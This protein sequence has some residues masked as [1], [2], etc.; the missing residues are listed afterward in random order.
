MGEFTERI[1]TLGSDLDAE[2]AADKTMLATVHPN[3]VPIRRRPERTTT[4]VH[5]SPAS[6]R[7]P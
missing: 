5:F 3:A 6:F 2:S 7:A 4:L 1:A